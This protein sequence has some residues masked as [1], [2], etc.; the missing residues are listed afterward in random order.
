MKIQCEL[1]LFCVFTTAASRARIW[2]V[3]LI[4]PPLASAAVVVYS[5]FG[6]APIV[7]G[8]FMLGPCFAVICVLSSIAVIWLGKRE[9][10]ALLLLFAERHVA[11]IAL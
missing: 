8:N 9:L 3:K 11:V 5:L 2:P 6:A 1:N 4:E 7:C 10:V